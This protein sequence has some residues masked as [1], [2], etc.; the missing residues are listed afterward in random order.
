M[1][2]KQKLLFLK[3]NSSVQLALKLVKV[4]KLITLIIVKVYY[5]PSNKNAYNVSR[6]LRMFKISLIF[7]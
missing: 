1:L 2:L 4:Q 6:Y 7:A 3:Q 5:F